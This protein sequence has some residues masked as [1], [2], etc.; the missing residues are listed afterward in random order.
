MKDTQN[1]QDY[2]TGLDIQNSMIQGLQSLRKLWT[3]ARDTNDQE[4]L[5]RVTVEYESR[6]IE[7][8]VRTANAK[9]VEAMGAFFSKRYR[10][11][12]IIG[13]N[14]SGKTVC[15]GTMCMARHLRDFAKK[16]EI[17]W[18]IAP[19]QEKSIDKQQRTIWESLPRMLLGDQ[20][21]DPKTGFGSVRPMVVVDPGENGRKILVRF[22]T[23][24]QWD[25]DPRS[26]ESDI[27]SG[28]WIDESIQE[29]LYD[30]LLPRLVARGGFANVSA[31]PDV[32]WMFD[33]FQNAKPDSKV[34]FIPLAIM[35]NAGNLPQGSIDLMKGQMSAEEAEMRIFGK[36]RFVSGVVYR[37]FIKEYAPD[38]HLQKP[39]VIPKD[40]PRFRTLDWGNDSPTACLWAAVSPNGTLYIYREYYRRNLPVNVHA[41]NIL[42]MS[43]GE[44]YRPKS[45]MVIADPA[46]FKRDQ[47]NVTSIADSFNQSGLYLTPGER[48]SV[49][50][51]YNQVQKVK[52]WLMRHLDTGPQIRIF[53]DC[54][55]LIW[56]M[57]RWKYKRDKD[58]KPM[59]S[60]SFENKNN[61]ALDALKYLIA[62]N[63]GNEYSS[64]LT[65]EDA[66]YG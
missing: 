30:A 62:A 18:C 57:R 19:N 15:M 31:I 51:E 14:Q 35:D 65:M 41:A 42:E 21:W 25:S 3:K 1:K 40:W 22:K 58:N 46:L 61:H 29:A 9:Q 66:D 20:T 52:R 32:P 5:Q 50:G 12:T 26:F 64:E 17:Y 13:G 11:V 7:R 6:M 56:E 39:F 8:T 44:E 23:A 24:S 59:E 53:D 48:A 60:E 2:Q 34:R 55:Y 16:D 54:E 33:R 27:I 47:A 28:V 43:R 36:F 37:E 4:L 38:G 10:T 45:G 49:V 63:P